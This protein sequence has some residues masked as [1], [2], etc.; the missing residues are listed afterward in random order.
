MSDNLWND[1]ARIIK[2]I[3]SDVSKCEDYEKLIYY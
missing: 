2:N 1:F 3:D